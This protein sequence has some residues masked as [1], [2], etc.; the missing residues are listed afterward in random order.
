LA[1]SIIYRSDSIEITFI[2]SEYPSTIAE[3]WDKEV[4]TGKKALRGRR[5]NIKMKPMSFKYHLIY[6]GVFGYI[7]SEHEFVDK[8]PFDKLQNQTRNLKIAKKELS[9]E[10][11]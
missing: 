6:R 1:V 9:V 3:K 10:T 8:N 2:Y 11:Q 7:G 4:L 5:G